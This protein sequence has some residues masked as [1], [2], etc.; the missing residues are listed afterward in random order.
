M[1]SL[2]PPNNPKQTHINSQN[3]T[4]NKKQKYPLPRSEEG[5]GQYCRQYREFCLAAMFTNEAR[6]C[7]LVV[8]LGFALYYVINEARI[9]SVYGLGHKESVY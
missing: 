5:L 6:I 9:V 7:R 1:R 4:N 8:G 2:A 3:I